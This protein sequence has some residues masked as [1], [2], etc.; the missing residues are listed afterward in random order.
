MRE[1]ALNRNNGEAL[2]VQ[3]YRRGFE[4]AQ[5]RRADEVRESS[6]ALRRG[7]I[8]DRFRTAPK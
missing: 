1:A 6:S 4:C 5:K 7:E 8:R 3:L 2:A